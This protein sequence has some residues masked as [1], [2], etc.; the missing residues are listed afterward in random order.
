[1]HGYSAAMAVLISQL[2]THPF[3]VIKKRLMVK[4][5]FKM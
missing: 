5:D 1:M 2:I 4:N 3:D